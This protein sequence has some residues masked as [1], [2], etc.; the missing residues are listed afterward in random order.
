VLAAPRLLRGDFSWLGLMLLGLSGAL[1]AWTLLHNRLGNFNIRP[2]PKAGGVLITTGPY[3]LMRHP[4]YTS[5]LL[6]A[7]ALA[8]A[9]E[10][11]TGCLAWAAL[12]L[13]LYLKSSLEERWL[14]EHHAQYEAYCLTCKRFL[15]WVF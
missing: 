2:A 11:L 8:S 6:M 7:A 15:P 13:V 4:M 1:A 5:V 14:R 9:A 10:P 3:R 12:A